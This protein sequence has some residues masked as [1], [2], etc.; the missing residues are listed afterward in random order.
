[1][2]K[3]ANIPVVSIVS[4]RHVKDLQENAYLGVK[5]V[6]MEKS[7]I[8]VIPFFMLK[9]IF[10]YFIFLFSMS[11]CL[12]N[13]VIKMLLYFKSFLKT[14]KVHNKVVMFIIKYCCSMSME[15]SISGT[16]YTLGSC[17]F[18]SL[19]YCIASHYGWLNFLEVIFLNNFKPKTCIS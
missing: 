10:I 14:L 2:E 8:K 7:V 16:G 19:L 6:F 4:T 1:M 5:L 18:H 11:I 15:K 3:T 9:T 12:Y 17:V 13:F